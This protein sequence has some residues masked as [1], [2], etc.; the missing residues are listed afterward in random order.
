MGRKNICFQN[1]Y[2]FTDSLYLN[3][4]TFIDYLDRFKKLCLSIFEWVNLPSSMDARYLELCLYMDGK[5]SFLKDKKYGLI[6][7]RCTSSGYVNIYGLPTKLNCYSYEFNTI[8][9]LYTRVT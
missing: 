5:A 9:S 7:T 6:N 3:N 8:R 2:K 4:A 1:N